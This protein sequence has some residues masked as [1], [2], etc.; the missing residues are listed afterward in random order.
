M[1]QH[2]DL[3]S[4]ALEADAI[5]RAHVVG[6]R[7]VDQY[8]TFKTLE[9]D[10]SYKGNVAEHSQIEL[11]YGI[12]S[13][14]KMDFARHADA[15]VP[16]L[17]VDQFFFL[18][19]PDHRH[20]PA[21]DAGTDGVD[22]DWYI[23][24]SGLRIF[25]DGQA[26]RFSQWSNPGGFVPVPQGHDPYDL[27]GDPRGAVSLDRAG[28]EREIAEAMQR[29]EHVALVLAADD[30]P[31]RRQ[32]L[33]QLAATG[34]DDELVDTEVGGFYSNVVAQRIVT[35]LAETLDLPLTLQALARSRGIPLLYLRHPFTAQQILNA[36]ADKALPLRSR[37]AALSLAEENLWSDLRKLPG[38]DAAVIALFSDR[39]PAVRIAAL[40]VRPT[41][42]PS[43]AVKAAIVARFGV[44]RD[45]QVRLALI[46]AAR[47]REMS[48]MLKASRKDL[49]IVTA[50][51]TRDVVRIQYGDRDEALNW[52]VASSSHLVLRHAGVEQ[53]VNTDEAYV[54]Y[55][56]G[57]TG[58]MIL[59]LPKVSDAAPR[60]VE[61]VVTLEEAEKRQ[62]PVT[63]RFTLGSV[64][65]EA[66]AADLDAGASVAS[67][68]PTPA[69]PRA[70]S[71]CGCETVGVSGGA[72]SALLLP[73]LALASARRR[74][75]RRATL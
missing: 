50:T 59:R 73:L 34:L 8:T 36:A 45:D 68:V 71:R 15:S 31:S 44:E 5:V 30:S 43:A 16:V 1:M 18:K 7:R 52:I 70:A 69:P 19:R 46:Q 6:E 26:Q 33:V 28:L 10:Q 21:P 14:Q 25:L 60:E 66:R 12:Y 39:E 9:I 51:R 38:A 64:S 4:L 62:P 22:R 54:G 17:G 2:H 67:E 72:G 41:A 40:D 3:T 20:R 49:P 65:L 55:S 61:L 13:M 48:G 63:R 58:Y 42:E 11:S 29:A 37:L 53:V 27:F 24:P 47:T 75:R 32:E 23:V 35:A 57:S 74:S 56:N